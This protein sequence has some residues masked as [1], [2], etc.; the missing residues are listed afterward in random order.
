MGSGTL[1]GA[2][3]V[4]VVLVELAGMLPVSEVQGRAVAVVA[5]PVESTVVVV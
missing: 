1:L 3:K 4:T 5:L 2:V